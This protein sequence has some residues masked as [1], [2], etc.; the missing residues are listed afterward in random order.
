MMICPVF[1]SAIG[2]TLFNGDY[3]IPAA[4]KKKEPKGSF[5]RLSIKADTVKAMILI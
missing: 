5:I 2:A 1:P 3:D 4:H